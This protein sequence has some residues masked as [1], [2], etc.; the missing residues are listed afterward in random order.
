MKNRREF[1]EICLTGMAVWIAGCGKQEST[2]TERTPTSG[3][4][5]ATNKVADISS[6]HGHRAIITSAQIS[7]GQGL[8]LSIQGGADHTHSISLTASEVATIRSGGRLA[9]T[10]S[11]NGHTHVV[12]FNPGSA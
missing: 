9:K 1:L 6:N 10:S 3:G 4:P 2:S 8:T 7:S 12:T 5:V 11:A